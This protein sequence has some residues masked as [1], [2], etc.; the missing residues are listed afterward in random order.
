MKFNLLYLNILL[1]LGLAGSALAQTP[2][3]AV[4]A[5]TNGEGQVPGIVQG[6][7]AIVAYSQAE[8]GRLTRIGNYLT[9]GNGGD[10]DG[11]EGLDP[12]ISAYAITKSL[13]NKFVIA[14]NAGSNT[15]TVMTVNDDFTLS[16]PNTQSTVDFGPNSVAYVPSDRPGVNGLVY[17]SNISRSQF[18]NMGEPAQQGSVIGFWL[19][20][21]GTL[22]PIANSRREL[23]NRPSAVQFSPNGEYIVV[24]SINSGSSALASG[25]EDEIVVYTVNDDGTLSAN[26]TDGET[27]TLRGNAEGRNLPSAIGFQIVG[28]NYVV[29]TEAREFRPDGTPPVFPGL[30]DGSV[31]TWQIMDN[32]ILRPIDMDVASGTNNTG[33]TA[34]WLD[35]SDDNTFFVSNA[36]E[37]GLA[38]YSFDNGSIALINQVAAQGTGATGNTTDPAAAFG[39]TD[40]WIDLWISDDGRYLYQCYGLTGEIGVFEIN[41]TELTLLQEVSGDLPSNNIQGIVSVG[42][43]ADLT[44]VGAVYAMSNGE[45]QIDGNVQGPNSV[46][47]Y[48]QA[49]N[50]MLTM[51]GSYPT[52]GNGGDFDGGE[53]LDPLISA[54]AITKTNDNRYVLAVNAGSNTVTSMGVNGDYSLDVVDTQSTQDVGPNSIAYVPS[55]RFGVNGLVY[56][57][58]ISRQEFVAQGEPAQ[59]GSLTGYWLLDDGTLFPIPDSRRELAN[60]P[61][62]VQIS[63]DGDFLVVT[64]INSGS[65]ALATGDEN[66]V[67]VYAVNAD[68]TLSAEPIT[69][70]RLPLK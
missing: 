21:N 45:G 57:S 19:L 10:F 38:S 70:S 50:G 9:G 62:A 46:V 56:V 41:G 1:L 68:G 23:A 43:Q 47:A 2:A 15:V 33:R 25:S 67:V 59:Q 54:Y 18:V 14:V 49:D 30:Q 28:D 51:I 42:P 37:A 4:Y 12:L 34:C 66:E 35:F 8:D 69:G 13:D 7:N 24:A 60:R 20:D 55:R 31:S 53:G 61:S 17:V 27:S 26:Q 39:T 11:G 65:S 64:S 44:P 58:N 63:P 52:G 5:M 22:A 36:I 32:G 16:A 48:S 40:G 6:P 3:G 29:V